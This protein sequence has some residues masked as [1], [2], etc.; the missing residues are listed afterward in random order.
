MM[1]T[2]DVALLHDTAYR[3]L[4]QVGVSGGAVGDE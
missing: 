3:E 2:T 4:V 1:L